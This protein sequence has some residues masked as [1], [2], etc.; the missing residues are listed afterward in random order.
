MTTTGLKTFDET[1]HITNI[2]LNE[3]GSRMGWDDRRKSYR[4]LRHVLHALRDRVPVSEAAQF[5]AQLPLLL[6]GVFYE[7][8]RAASAEEK[9]RSVDDFLAPLA[10]A[11]SEDDA[12]DP[13]AAFSEAL[14]V[15]RAH[16][17]AG[18]MADMRHN[19]PADLRALWD[20]SA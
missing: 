5:A 14:A 1:L 15:I 6:R 18:E 8:W 10:A 17:S 9:A 19:M 7:G 16:V 20:E 4:L 2:W 12:F 11:F 13:L 3:I